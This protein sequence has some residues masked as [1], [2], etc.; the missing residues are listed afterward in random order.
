MKIRVILADDHAIVREGIKAVLTQQAPDIEIVG[1]AANGNEVLELAKK[2]GADVYVLDAAMPILNGV[3]TASRLL[4]QFPKSKVIMLSMYDDK[5]L[6]SKA[7]QCGVNGYILK[8]K[9]PS[10]IVKAISDVYEGKKIFCPKFAESLSIRTKLPKT[11]SVQRR[12]KMLTGREQEILTLIAEG[13]S[14][15]QIARRLAISF[16]TV[17][18][19]RSNIK[20]KLDIHKQAE[21]IRY[22]LKKDLARL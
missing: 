2:S 13:H 20:H 1:E 8:N 3:E 10:L 12:R 19:H 22:A 4:K 18:V 11:T 17:H 5:S 14:D 9:A 16:N 7:V 21:L 15:K 6:V